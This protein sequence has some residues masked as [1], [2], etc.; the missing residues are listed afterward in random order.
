M[1]PA[2]Y[3]GLIFCHESA[4]PTDGNQTHH[5]AFLVARFFFL[6]AKG[7]HLFYTDM[8]SV[9]LSDLMR[10]FDFFFFTVI[11]DPEFLQIIDMGHWNWVLRIDFFL[12]TRMLSRVP[13][14]RP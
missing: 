6:A 3:E 12:W 2:P 1:T 11:W 8:V 7:H 9:L 4:R 13:S 10:Y 14:A 5:L